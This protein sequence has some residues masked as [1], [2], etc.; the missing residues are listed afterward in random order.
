VVCMV[1]DGVIVDM[2]SLGDPWGAL[3]R[4]RSPCCSLSVVWTVSYPRPQPLARG[5]ALPG[6]PGITAPLRTAVIFTVHTAVCVLDREVK[7]RSS[8]PSA[9]RPRSRFFAFGPGRSLDRERHVAVGVRKIP[10][11]SIHLRDRECDT[12]VLPGQRFCGRG[13]LWGIHHPAH[14]SRPSPNRDG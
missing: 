4:K 3:Q 1:F 2:T 8:S 12:D 5:V 7:R 13:L 14:S 11:V 10:A 6:S 9:I